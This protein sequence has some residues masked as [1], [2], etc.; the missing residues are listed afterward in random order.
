MKV[1]RQII[2]GCGT[3]PHVGEHPG[4]LLLF[5]FFLLGGAAG[6]NSG[7]VGIVIGASIMVIVFAPIYL[8]GAYE[9]AKTSDAIERL[10][11][12]PK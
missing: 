11:G 12:A 6:R 10:K 4:T 5:A 3:L 2:R 8:W 9:R 1:L 7:A